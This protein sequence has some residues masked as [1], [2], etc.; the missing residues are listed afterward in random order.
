MKFMV[1]FQLKPGCKNKAVAMFEARGPNRDLA[2]TL[3]SAWVGTHSDVAFVLVESDAQEL[4]AKVGERWREFGEF[5]I[6]PVID[7]EQF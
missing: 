1:E 4:V 5:Q 6:H 3:R 7:V 2:V